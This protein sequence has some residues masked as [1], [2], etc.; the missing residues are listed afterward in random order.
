MLLEFECYA[1]SGTPLLGKALET[2]QGAQAKQETAGSRRLGNGGEIK[3]GG[4]TGI[5]VRESAGE[6]IAIRH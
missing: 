5:A 4:A 3:G 1:G 6:V 2:S